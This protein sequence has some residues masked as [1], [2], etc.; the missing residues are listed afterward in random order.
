M[1]DDVDRPATESFK[2]LKQ[3]LKQEQA[4]MTKDDV[5]REYGGIDLDNIPK[6]KHVWV[7]RGIVMSCEG[8]QHPS[9]R[10]FLV[11]Q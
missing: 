10:H 3:R 5:L 7:K 1:S 9:H 2:E 11:K 8:A 4:H 6:Q